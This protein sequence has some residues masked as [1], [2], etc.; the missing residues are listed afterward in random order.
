VGWGSLRPPGP[1]MS[2]SGQEKPS[3]SE[4]AIGVGQLR[5]WSDRGRLPRLA[6]L[7]SLRLLSS[8][9][10]HVLAVSS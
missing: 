4:S 1:R 8:N 3:S 6:F 7:Q 10:A 9:Q 2:S 5:G